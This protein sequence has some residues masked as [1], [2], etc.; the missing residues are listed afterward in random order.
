MSTR[1]DNRFNASLR[2]TTIRTRTT[3]ETETTEAL[4][5]RI[6][7]CVYWCIRVVAC[8]MRAINGHMAPKNFRIELEASAVRGTVIC[9]ALS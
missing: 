1:L 5:D 8:V 7:Q 2:Y 4:K 6:M 9:T 3:E